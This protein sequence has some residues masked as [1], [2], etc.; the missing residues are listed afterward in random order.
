MP[1]G[2]QLFAQQ[3]VEI[4]VE[5]TRGHQFRLLALQRS[6]GGI[7]RIGK[8]RFLGCLALGVEPLKHFPRHENLTAYLKLAGEVAPGVQ[9]QRNAA[10]G[11][12]VGRHVVAMHTVATRHRPHQ[13]ALLVGERDAQSVVLHF[14]AH[15]EGLAV[16][17]AAHAVVPVGHILFA[18]GVGQRE[19]RI[20]VGHLLEFL[21]QVGAHTLRRRVGVG[22]LGMARLQ[23]LQLLH[24]EIE[25]LVADDWLVQHVVAVVMVVQFAS[26]L[27]NSLFLVHRVSFPVESFCGTLSTAPQRYEIKLR[28]RRF[29][30]K[31][32]FLATFSAL[33][34]CLACR[35]LSNF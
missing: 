27:L 23:F 8:E 35:E 24:L 34:S 12:H 7:A 31:K 28:N 10:D 15:L 30:I 21:V 16:Q 20:S 13:A 22:H 4:G 5:L 18:V 25:L 29:S 3:V 11:L 2:G 17:T 1:F 32:T 9:H 26:Q 19:H 33:I 6:A 14:A